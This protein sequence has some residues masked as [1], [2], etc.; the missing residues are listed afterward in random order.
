MKKNKVGGL[1]LLDFKISVI[2]GFSSSH[3]WMWEL[4]Y[5]ESW[6]PKNLCFWTRVLEKTLESPL[7]FKEI[8]PVHP[9]G[10]QFWIFTGRP[11]AEAETPILRPPHANIWLIWKDP[12]AG[13]DWRR[14]EKGTTEDE[15]VGWHHG[16]DGLMWWCIWVGSGSWWWTRKPGVLQSM[17]SQRIG[18]DWVTELNWIRLVWYWWKARYIDWWGKTVSKDKLIIVWLNNFWWVLRQWASL[19]AQR[20]KNLPAVQ[21][22]WVWSLGWEDSPGG[23][24][25]PLQY[26]CLENPHGQKS[27]AGYSLWSHKELDATEWLSTHKAIQQGKENVFNKQH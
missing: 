18:H 7:D 27:L 10:N 14:E 6:A 13:K 9:K 26:S 16:C 15:M 22:T 8:Q 5:K 19:V 23:H 3:V 20:V 24:G 1:L 2:Y 12:D 4:E 25:N 17:G 11:H 21:E